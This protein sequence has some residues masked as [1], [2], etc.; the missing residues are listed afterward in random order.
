MAD[1]RELGF[2]ESQEASVHLIESGQIVQARFDGS[3]LEVG[4]TIVKE[5]IGSEQLALRALLYATIRHHDTDVKR[6]AIPWV[7]IIPS[8][9]LRQGYEEGSTL[10]SRA[11][12][13][14]PL[15]IK[16]GL[17]APEQDNTPIL[18]ARFTTRMP[19]AARTP[20][21]SL[22]KFVELSTFE[23]PQ[24]GRPKKE[25]SHTESKF[26]PATNSIVTVLKRGNAMTIEE[27]HAAYEALT[28]RKVSEG[29]FGSLLRTAVDELGVS[30][31][32]R[33][34]IGFH[35]LEQEGKKVAYFHW[36]KQLVNLP[37]NPR[38]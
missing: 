17:A 37:R 6:S 10:L 24:T 32:T 25:S 36:K 29:V 33:G 12:G 38:L 28:D 8:R 21:P 31:Q 30:K 27:I 26:S 16:E 35:A 5:W 34:R 4:D 11:F 13:F 18:S 23:G 15:S 22:T 19:P 2:V 9:S 3:I 1:I 14:N 20:S 7:K